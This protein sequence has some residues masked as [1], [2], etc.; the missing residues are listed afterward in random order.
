MKKAVFLLLIFFLNAYALIFFDFLSISATSEDSQTQSVISGEKEFE[1][2]NPPESRILRGN[3]KIAGNTMLCEK[4]QNGECILT[5]GS[6]AT[7]AGIDL[8]F[9]DVDSNDSTPNSSESLL[10]VPIG[11][12]LEWAGLFWQG[13]VDDV[14]T[15][16]LP[17]LLKKPSSDEYFEVAPQEVATLPSYTWYGE[18][19]GYTYEAFSEVTSILDQ[20]S[21]GGWYRVANVPC[22]EGATIS[23]YDGLGN[24]GAWT[25]VAIYSHKEEKIRNIVVYNGYKKVDG[26]VSSDTVT[27]TPSGFFTPKYGAVDSWLYLFAAEGDKYLIGDKLEVNSVVLENGNGNDDNFFDSSVENVVREPSIEN[28]NGIDIHAKEIGIDGDDS[29]P[30]II[31]NNASS[32]EIVLSTSGDTYFPSMITF[33]TEMYKPKMCYTETLYING[34][35]ITHDNNLVPNGSL[36]TAR[37]SIKNDDNEEATNFVIT[38]E[39]IGTDVTYQPNST[40]VKNVND[41][42]FTPQT[43]EVGDDL[44]DAVSDEENLTLTIRLGEE[45]NS[46]NGGRFVPQQGAMVEYNFTINNSGTY[47]P[48]YYASY[49]Y[50][51][52][53]I[54]YQV[55]HSRLDKCM[56][57]NNTLISYV[58]PNGYFNVVNDQFNSPTDP[59]D[60][61]DP[62]NALYTQ[63]VNK[64]FAV[65]VLK[66][67]SDK[68]TLIPFKGL[69]QLELIPTPHFEEDASEEE[70]AQLCQAQPTLWKTTVPFASTS[71]A[72]VSNIR[73]SKAL[74][75]AT[76]RVNYVSAPDGTAVVSDK[77]CFDAT[78]NCIWGMLTQAYTLRHGN[79]CP[80]GRL[81]DGRYC[82]CARECNYANCGDEPH[83]AEDHANE[84]C[85]RCV[86]GEGGI[87]STLCARDNFAIRPKKFRV[88]GDSVLKRAGEKFP[89]IIKAVDEDNALVNTGDESWVQ[90]VKDYNVSLDTLSITTYT[91]E[92]PASMASIMLSNVQAVDPTITDV[93]QITNCPYGGVL[94]SDGGTFFDGVLNTQFKYTETGIKEINVSEK[95][96]MEFALVDRDDTPDEL[97]FIEPATKIMDKD[98]IDTESILIFIPYTIQVY[99][100]SY[101]TSTNSN[102][103]Y[104]SNSVANAST[105]FSTPRMSARVRYKIVAKNKD[106]LVTRNFTK[107]CFP[108]VNAPYFNGMKLNSTFDLF[109]D[110]EMEIDT[111]TSLNF[112]LEDNQSRAIWTMAPTLNLTTGSTNL[113]RQ[114]LSPFQFEA[115]Y[116]EAI[117]HFNIPRL[118][119]NPLSPVAVKVKDLNTSTSWMTNE[120]ATNNFLPFSL[121]QTNYFYYGRVHAGDEGI[122]TFTNDH[123]DVNI[124]FEIYDPTHK[125]PAHIAGGASIDDIEWYVNSKHISDLFGEINSI[126]DKEGHNVLVGS[127][128]PFSQATLTPY[129]NGKRIMRFDYDGSKGYPYKSTFFIYPSS[130]LIF[131]KY[132]PNALFNRFRVMFVKQ[133]EWQGVGRMK[134]QSE[135]E[136]SKKME[137]RINW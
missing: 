75:D 44:V 32:A 51:I 13:Y 65:K 31:G 66:L 23:F 84:E 94:S 97:R 135:I 38:R 62:L 27:I 87:N 109:L 124:F 99:D 72:L 98:N 11:A 80:T 2:V 70:K 1:I 41:N 107:S 113:V 5:G 110:T 86:F 37:L 26:V 136:T 20:D 10:E 33:A 57:F 58:P 102:W 105:T 116:G 34:E 112:Y 119:N 118:T 117:I 7:N 130:W 101:T 71:Q 89:L 79:T 42:D 54:T 55:E 122:N 45:A 91:F 64:P 73:Y 104:I 137:N 8:K 39:F 127:Y 15:A 100:G 111:N 123:A 67:D 82:E 103:L 49:T 25:L 131:N 56:D 6:T 114:W 77:P 115:G 29:H 129:V 108:D 14:Y 52:G 24:Y 83:G 59:L 60:P 133:G 17:V 76:F 128:P 46:Q 85:L 19:S 61:N 53:D 18:L 121:N 4:D 106:G 125:D 63:I 35:E 93:S 3:I 92:P 21:P 96:G 88:F 90:G 43:D 74:K 50:S 68:E 78:Y 132:D 28:N 126:K 30:Q 48:I 22:R 69:I 16:S 40:R 47:E 9:V 36:L 120:G 95:D 12:K 81:E 134:S